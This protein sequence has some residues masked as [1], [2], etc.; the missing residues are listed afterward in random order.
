MLGRCGCAKG[1][2]TFI[3]LRGYIEC[4][5]PLH[6]FLA[7]HVAIIVRCKEPNKEIHG[8]ITTHISRSIIFILYVKRIVKFYFITF[9][10]K[11]VVLYKNV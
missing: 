11:I 10:K 9:F 2:Q 6:Y 3:C 5:Y 7:F 1:F 8:S 4:L